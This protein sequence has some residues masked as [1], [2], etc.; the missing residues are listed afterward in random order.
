[1][2]EY[3]DWV[4]I[5]S[6]YSGLHYVDSYLALHDLHWKHHEERNREVASLMSEVQNYYLNLYDLGRNSR[7]GRVEDMPTVDEAKQA[8]NIDLQK[9]EEFVKS[10]I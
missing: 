6:F 8:L 1:M 4:S 2:E 3:P 5:V 10:R 9:I 7:Y